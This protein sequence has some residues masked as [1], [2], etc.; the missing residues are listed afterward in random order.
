MWTFDYYSKSRR[1][2]SLFIVRMN[3]HAKGGVRVGC[4][5]VTILI[6]DVAGLGVD[7]YLK[8]V[9]RQITFERCSWD[10]RRIKPMLRS[11]AQQTTPKATTDGV[12]SVP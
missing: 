6:L 2:K 5:S 4:K 10:I 3:R 11:L 9:S 7:S 12:W 8:V 1:A